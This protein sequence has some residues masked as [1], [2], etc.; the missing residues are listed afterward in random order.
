MKYAEMASL[1]EKDLEQLYQ[2]NEARE[3]FLLILSFCGLANRHNY[4]LLKEYLLDQTAEQQLLAYLSE[5]KQAKPIQYILGYT[6]FYQLNFKLDSSVLIP[7]PETEEL[8][9]WLI[10]SFNDKKSKI[11]ILDVGTGSGCIAISLKSQLANAEVLGLDIA[12]DSIELAK[13]N[14]RLNQLEVSFCQDDALNW[15]EDIKSQFFD[16]IV[17]NP[18]YIQEAEQAKMQPTVLQFEPHRALFV[19]DEDPLCFYHSIADF[20]TTNLKNG[21]ALFFEINQ[22]F[23][24]EI[25]TM[26]NNKGF[27][28]VELR[29]DLNN[30]DRMV[31]AIK[32]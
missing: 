30:N 23:G 18:P 14:A 24:D 27:I 6:S 31:R 3:L 12:A 25:V 10:S 16:V 32:P 15:S 8:V 21:G 11:N 9:H 1:F 2:K 20:A 19:A 17:S 29:K 5:L 13:Y 22:L 4:H 7:R 26:L 28:E